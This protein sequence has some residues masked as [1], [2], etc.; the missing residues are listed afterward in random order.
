MSEAIGWLLFF[1]MIALSWTFYRWTKQ[2]KDKEDAQD[3]NIRDHEMRL[4]KV[5]ES[6][7]DNLTG[8]MV[9][10]G[11]LRDQNEII[12]AG[13]KEIEDEVANLHEHVALNVKET[14]ALDRELAK[15]RPIVRLELPTPPELPKRKPK[16]KRMIMAAT[17]TKT[18]R[19]LK[20]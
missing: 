11:K 14:T 2:D 6:T 5:E 20:V 12:M 13:M 4:L 10:S 1:G 18:S 17:Q 16:R 7:R 3:R 8:R 15:L 9:L 19:K